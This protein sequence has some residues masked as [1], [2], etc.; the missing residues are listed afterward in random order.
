MDY[1]SKSK[2]IHR[3][4]YIKKILYSA[5]IEGIPEPS[6]I[7]P[8][9]KRKNQ[10]VVSNRQERAAYVIQWNGKDKIAKKI[11]K[12]YSVET[13]S[14]YSTNFVNIGKAS[15]KQHLYSGTNVGDICGDA[16]PVNASLY[17]YTKEDGV[18]RLISNVIASS[19]MA[20]SRKKFYYIDS[21]KYNIVEYD[22]NSCEDSISKLLR[23]IVEN[24]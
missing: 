24:R 20:W 9:S 1:L 23:L 16:G 7:I 10:F 19:G 4:D 8:V 22:W 5:T 2:N 13:A 12:I 15:P 11:R 17:R 14:K 6:Y 3:Y 21:C 18:T